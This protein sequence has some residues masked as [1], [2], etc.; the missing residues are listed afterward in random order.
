MQKQNSLMTNLQV[1]IDISAY[2]QIMQQRVWIM[3]RQY[4]STINLKVMKDKEIYFQT[5]I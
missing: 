2:F 1:V 4:F 3:Q 5:I